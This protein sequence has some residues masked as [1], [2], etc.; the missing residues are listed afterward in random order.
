MGGGTMISAD[1][2][3]AYNKTS[4][5]GKSFGQSAAYQMIVTRKG[6][7]NATIAGQPV[8]VG[9]N[10]AVN[11]SKNSFGAVG[12]CNY[13][14]MMTPR[15]DTENFQEMALDF[16]PGLVDSIIRS[17]MLRVKAANR[18]CITCPE[19]KLVDVSLHKFAEAFYADPEFA[20]SLMERMEFAGCDVRTKFP[21]LNAAFAS[22]P[23]PDLKLEDT[24]SAEETPETPA[25]T[26]AEEAPE[27]GPEDNAVV[28]KT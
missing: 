26:P 12:N 10:H 24:T 11:V 3:E 14:L 7:E 20:R 2:A 17:G 15:A 16:N 6:F 23:A 21:P 28:G 22:A 5:G 4:I 18:N 19:L 8:K 13:R 25:E 1:V 27:D 9:V